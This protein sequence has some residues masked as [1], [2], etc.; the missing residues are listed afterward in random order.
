MTKVSYHIRRVAGGRYRDTRTGR[1]VSRAV[2][3]RS[4]AA[5]RAVAARAARIAAER[6]RRSEAA[7]RG[8]EA[9]RER[10]LEAARA[11]E[12]ARR[13]EAARRGW[14]ARRERAAEAARAA[15][16][17]RRARGERGWDPE[18]AIPTPAVADA[19]WSEPGYRWQIASWKVRVAWDDIY[20][21]VHRALASLRVPMRALVSV[22]ARVAGE[23]IALSPY[24]P[25]RAV[26]YDVQT[27][28][29]RLRETPSRKWEVLNAE[30]VDYMEQAIEAVEIVWGFRPSGG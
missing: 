30:G 16:R 14:E 27:A 13:A 7:R 9:R 18:R 24:L 21:F 12:R 23:W 20:A 6:A 3:E 2:A 1:F 4:R 25:R 15:E 5:Q 22:R 17:A 11:A 19:P 8:W 10:A 29:T 26:E 28:R